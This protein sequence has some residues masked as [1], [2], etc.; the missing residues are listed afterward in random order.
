MTK[1]DSKLRTLTENTLE[2]LIYNSCNQVIAK[3]KAELGHNLEL[4][5]DVKTRWNSFYSESSHIID[6]KM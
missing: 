4:V 6:Y 1:M 3:I 5:L 2:I